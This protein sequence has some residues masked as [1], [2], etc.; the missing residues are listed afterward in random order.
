MASNVDKTICLSELLTLFHLRVEG[1][2]SQRIA[3]APGNTT[4]FLTKEHNKWLAT[5][6]RKCSVTIECYLN[7]YKKRLIELNNYPSI[8]TALFQP[9]EDIEPT[10]V[11]LFGHQ[12]NEGYFVDKISF[13]VIKD[14]QASIVDIYPYE[15]L[16]E[17]SWELFM[18]Q[19]TIHQLDVNFDQIDDV[20]LFL[21]A[22]GAEGSL[23]PI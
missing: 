2:Y 11:Q 10:V 9:L 6:E 4:F 1:A 18:P 5:R 21:G 20:V 7:V 19:A 13:S 22:Q 16:N 17:E 14:E 3:L 12:N 23:L 8:G 15:F